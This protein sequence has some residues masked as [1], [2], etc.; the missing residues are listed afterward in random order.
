V[1]VS[2]GLST[3]E[4]V[5]AVT[6]ALQR[7]RHGDD[8][9]VAEIKST[10]PLLPEVTRSASL[11]EIA[12]GLALLLACYPTAPNE[13]RQIFARTL[14]KDVA[15][16]SP[17]VFMLENAIVDLRRSLK[18]RPT[19]SEVFE[20][21][22]RA[23]KLQR[24]LV[25]MRTAIIR[26][27]EAREEHRRAKE[28]EEREEAHSR[29]FFQ[30]LEIPPE[31]WKRKKHPRSFA[32]LRGNLDLEDL[33]DDLFFE[34]CCQRRGIVLEPGCIPELRPNDEEILFFERIETA[35]YDWARHVE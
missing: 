13:N 14:A 18:F 9:D 15:A 25:K 7:W 35:I 3:C 5:E 34:W 20:A 22:D 30:L 17:S 21:L 16:R 12:T 11:D 19:I 31:E 2:D 10:F 26:D 24:N 33:V 1:V 29:L 4:A 28:R 6:A 32:L 23:E 27:E 8:D